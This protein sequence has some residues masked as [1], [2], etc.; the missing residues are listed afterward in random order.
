MPS[1]PP[2]E[3]YS[4]AIMADGADPYAEVDWH[5]LREQVAYSHL[6]MNIIRRL[7]ATLAA[8]ERERDLLAEF[9]RAHEQGKEEPMRLAREAIKERDEALKVR[10][11]HLAA[12]RNLQESSRGQLAKRKA[13]MQERDRLRADLE[14]AEGLLEQTLR[15]MDRSKV[16][17]FLTR[18]QPQPEEE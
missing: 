17:A 5:Y 10:E 9:C 14:R 13:L 12:I 15:C 8:V 1:D 18:A 2:A 3:P 6:R 11:A 16:R 7:A 4:A